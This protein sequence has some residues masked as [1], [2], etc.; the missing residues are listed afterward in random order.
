MLNNVSTSTSTNSGIVPSS[1][2]HENKHRR[3]KKCRLETSF[4]PDFITTFLSYFF[5]INI[6]NDEFLSIYLI[7]EEPKTYDEQ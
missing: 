2:E 5:Y 3:S 6:L 1:N 7:E 4:I